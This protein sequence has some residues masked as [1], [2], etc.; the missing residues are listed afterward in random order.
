MARSSVAIQQEILLC[1]ILVIC[2][3]TGHTFLRL[4]FCRQDLPLYKK[5]TREKYALSKMMY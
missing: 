3:L 2:N 5:E 4:D 1:S